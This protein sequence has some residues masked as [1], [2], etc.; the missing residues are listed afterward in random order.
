MRESSNSMIINKHGVSFFII[1]LLLATSI[2]AAIS[3]NAELNWIKPA[4]DERNT[5][6]HPQDTINK[7]NV[8]NLVLSWIYQVPEDPFK[9]PYVAPALGLQTAPLVVS[10]IVYIATFYNRIIAINAET[11]AEVWQYQADVMEFVDEEWWWPVLSQKSLTYH[12]GTIYMMASDCRIIALDALNGAEI[13]VI[14]DVCKDVE[15]NT[16]L[17]FGEH[18]PVIF[19]DVLIARPSVQDGGGRGFVVAYDINTQEELW[20]WFSVPPS[21]GDPEWDFK[22][23]DK[24]NIKAYPGDWGDTDLIG[25]G[26]V[27]SMFAI[28]QAERTIYFTTGSSSGVFDAALRPGPNLY[29][30]SIIA[31]D[32]DSGEMKWYY[33]V[34]P[35]DI[36]DHEVGWSVI[37]AET[38]INGDMKK[39]I[40]A[41][42]KTDHVFVLDA[43]TGKTL[44]TPLMLGNNAFNVPNDDAG[45]N[46]D[47]T[48]SQ[49]SLVG[50]SFCPGGNGGIEHAGAYSSGILYYVSQKV[51][52]TVTEGPVD[53]K[54]KDIQG[55]IYGS[56]PGER[57]N[58]T[59]FSINVNDMSINWVFEMPN[60]YQSSGVMVSGGVVY[61][62]DRASVMYAV[63]VETG[64]EL[65]KIQWGG[66]GA[67]T[68]TLGA[69]A[70]GDMMLFV[71]SG[72]GQVAANTP[73]IIAAFK[74]PDDGTGQTSI[75]GDVQENIFIL[76]A[77]AA[78]SIAIYSVYNN[79]NRG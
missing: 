25:G 21:G 40:M 61:L 79:K 8:D 46:A 73:G 48:I 17:Y 30:S 55:F 20:R 28:D 54:G 45:N 78:V 4:A 52:W 56:V 75:I 5:N 49:R 44:H 15:G 24:G 58:S 32:V 1:F 22:D 70:R 26:A 65:R 72:G 62:V 37:L 66:L 2:P 57:Q 3:Q 63:D 36:N 11:G 38:E 10:G 74:L 71:P 31:L 68:V 39:V 7:D 13:F 53:Y 6:F 29:A 9:I 33:Q 51:C 67:G 12:E 59:L 64:K 19:E 47:L 23:A 60:R 18:G 42:S 41:G 76:I 35:H 14:K 50:K 77:L 34:V 69:T 43:E 16:G 27:W